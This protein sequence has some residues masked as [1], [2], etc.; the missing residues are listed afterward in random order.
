MALCNTD[1]SQ[2]GFATGLRVED[3]S[4]LKAIKLGFS[5]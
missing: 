3:W 4:V 1:L 5:R 2:A